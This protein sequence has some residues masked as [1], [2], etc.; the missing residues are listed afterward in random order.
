MIASDIP[1]RYPLVVDSG[2]AAATLSRSP[3]ARRRSPGRSHFTDALGIVSESG[4]YGSCA[5]SRA[6][7]VRNLRGGLDRFLNLRDSLFLCL[8]WFL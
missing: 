7:A 1:G 5:R 3:V 6:L 4:Q 8:W 2:V